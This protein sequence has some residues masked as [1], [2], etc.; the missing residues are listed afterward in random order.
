MKRRGG[1][2]KAIVADPTA[3]AILRKSVKSGTISET[4]VIIQIMIERE[5]MDFIFLFNLCYSSLK[6]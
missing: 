2:I 1:K 4:P 6:N 5:M 3:P